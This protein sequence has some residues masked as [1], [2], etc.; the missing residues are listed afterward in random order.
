ML[1]ESSR[2]EASIEEMRKYYPALSLSVSAKDN[3]E[4]A[5]WSGR[6]QPIRTR[7]GLDQLLEDIHHERPYYIVPGGEVLHHPECAA[8]HT[9]NAWVEKLSRPFAV[10]EV[11]IKY[12]GGNSH[13]AAYVRD[14]V[15]PEAK[16]WHMFGDGSICPYAPWA[17]IWRWNEHT[18]VDFMGHVLGWLIKWTVRDQAGVWLG[19]EISHDPAFL[20]RNIGRNNQCWCG[21]GKKYK[22]CHRE[23]DEVRAQKHRTR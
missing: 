1:H 21:S 6:V 8:P 20:L 16:R 5:I 23:P 4:K 18:V 15:I 22:K 17:D 3:P 2:L 19:L 11:D 12:L 13:P 14:P 10:Y 9:Q 7:D